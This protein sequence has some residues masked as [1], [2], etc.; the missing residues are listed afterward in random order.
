LNEHPGLLLSAALELLDVPVRDRDWERLEPPQRRLRIT[1]L[2]RVLLGAFCASGPS[3]L[4]CEDLHWCDPESLEFIGTLCENPPGSRLLIL[5]THRPELVLPW[6]DQPYVRSCEIRALDTGASERLLA[7]LLGASDSL[8]ALR[9]WLAQRTDGNPFFIEESARAVLE[10]GMVNQSERLERADVPAS[11]EALLNA[12][13]DRLPEPALELLQAAAVLDEQGPSEVLRAVVQLQPA[14]FEARL[15]LLA[16][17]ELLYE[18][19]ML[20]PDDASAAPA[21]TIRFKH[22][23]VQEVVYKRLVRPRRR[24]LH[25]RV[26]EVLEAQHSSRLAEQ[27]ERLAEHAYRAELWPQCAEYQRLA[28]VRAVTRGATALATAH[29]DRGLEAISRL[30]ETPERARLAIDLRLTALAALL[31][32]GAIERAIALLLEAAEIAEA[33]QDNGRLARVSSQLS[34]QLWCVARY[35][36]ARQRAEQSLALSMEL[37]GDQFALEASANYNLA[38]VQ[39][40]CGE[41]AE[42]R[43]RLEQ[44]TAQFTGG[45]ERRRLGWAGYPSVLVRTFVIVNASMTGDFHD[46]DRAY[47]QG[48]AIADELGHAFSRTMLME[49]YGLCLLVRGE[50]ERAAKLLSECLALCKQESVV[51]MTPASA[52]H[53][54]LAL[55]A[56]GEREH[57]RALIESTDDAELAR[58]GHYATIYKLLALSELARGSGESLRARSF[59]ERAVAETARCE[60]HGFHALSLLQLASVLTDRGEALRVYDHTLE[61]AET[62]GMRPCKALALQG[63]AS[64]LSKLGDNVQAAMAIEHARQI[65]T[66]LDAPA[67]LR[68]VNE[69]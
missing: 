35:E 60:E 47:E 25:A 39:H 23:L 24:A 7:S 66:D 19:L 31:P 49:E 61:R 59:A 4:L 16:R 34:T 42:S 8:A 14:E 32:A 17:S 64:V 11:I 38:M 46:A 44:L 63:K 41:F 29:L 30:P 33:M 37:E 40:A 26:I 55:L 3:V 69:L 9:G 27:V 5:L 53:L 48:R 28:C 36:E 56:L 58:A 20:S 65:W 21:R 6:R 57:A 51:A 2:L 50:V 68:R 45:A 43:A 10:T 1:E 13:V 22:A 62:L 54:G 52:T 18:A 12:R 15:S 67:R